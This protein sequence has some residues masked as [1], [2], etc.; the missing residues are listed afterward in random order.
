MGHPQGQRRSSKSVA[1]RIQSDLEKAEEARHR[2]R[3]SSWA[4]T[5]RAWPGAREE[6]NRLIEE[7]RQTAE[8]LRRD[9]QAKAEQ[10]SQHIVAR[11]Q[12]E[13]RAERDRVFQELRAQVGVLSVELAGRILGQ[14]LDASRHQR[15]VDDYIKDLSQ[16]PAGGNGNGTAPAGDA[17][18]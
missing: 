7:S 4:S 16:L 5:A 13:I 3:A 10:E 8:S 11:A 15:L 14:E 9:M 12:E 17:G 2:G 18:A 6:A 1:T